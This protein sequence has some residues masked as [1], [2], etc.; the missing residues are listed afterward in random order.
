MNYCISDGGKR[1]GVLVNVI[2]A[3]YIEPS[4]HCGMHFILKS[5]KILRKDSA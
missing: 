2:A 1:L 5:L 4:Q 3:E